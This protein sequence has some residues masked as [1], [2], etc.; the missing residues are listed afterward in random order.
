MDRSRPRDQQFYELLSV[1]D[2]TTHRVNDLIEMSRLSK[3]TDLQEAL[4]FN[5]ERLAWTSIHLADFWAFELRLGIPGKENQAFDILFRNGLLAQDLARKL[6]NFSE[7]RTLSRRDPSLINWD[8]LAGTL[9]DEL[10]VVQE[11]KS[12]IMAAL[13][14]KSFGER[15]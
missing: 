10:K 1:L 8:Y 15:I 14:N 2:V 9:E 11:W 6:R 7:F 4:C 5:L 13:A 3:N 12:V